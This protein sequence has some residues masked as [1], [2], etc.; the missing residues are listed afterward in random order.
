MIAGNRQAT[1]E[2]SPRALFKTITVTSKSNHAYP[3]RSI[4]LNYM[5]PKSH[6][7]DIPVATKFKASSE[8]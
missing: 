7:N 2:H 5:A 6:K 1:N 4:T 3:L 8:L